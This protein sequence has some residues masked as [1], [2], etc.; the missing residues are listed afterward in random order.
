MKFKIFYISVIS[1]WKLLNSPFMMLYTKIY[2]KW[3]NISLKRVIFGQVITS[4]MCGQVIVTSKEMAV[5]VYTISMKV[6][7]P[8]LAHPMPNLPR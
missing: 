8:T 1:I 2:K 4:I 5:A 6:H 3:G 7:F